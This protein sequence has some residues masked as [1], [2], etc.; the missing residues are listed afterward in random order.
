MPE[1]HN[2]DL[3]EI[4]I[5]S[6][7]IDK[8]IGGPMNAMIKAQVN[9]NWQYLDFLK[10]VCF[11]QGKAE[12]LQFD[13]EELLVDSEGG[14][15]GVQE[16]T[17]RLPLAAAV[18][19]PNLVLETG[20]VDFDFEVTQIESTTPRGLQ[21][22][23]GTQDVPSIK[24]KVTHKSTETRKTDKRAKYSIHAEVKRESPPESLMRIIDFLTDS[25]TQSS[26]SWLL[27]PRDLIDPAGFA[28]RLQDIRDPVSQFLKGQ[29]SESTRELLEEESGK[30]QDLISE[31]LQKALV[32]ELNRL[33]Q[34]DSIFG[35]QRFEHVT[36]REG[37]QEL[38]L[39]NPKGEALL[40][41]NRWLLEDAYPQEIARN[42][43]P[44]RSE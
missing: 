31:A 12:M 22:S 23:F 20:S 6:L 35:R 28:A 19:H 33:L 15:G 34:G 16:R 41:L 44:F 43:S 11:P 32:Q 27:R 38:R 14:L 25:A 37:T 42:P 8:M 10:Q 7:D 21:K 13:Y 17:I 3:K 4:T 9:A 29:F 2:P 30:E 18:T 1:K 36:L 39:K 40:V 24:G 26:R 5:H